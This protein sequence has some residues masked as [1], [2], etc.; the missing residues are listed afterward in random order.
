MRWWRQPV[1][2]HHVQGAVQHRRGARTLQ[3]ADFTAAK[4]GPTLGK[5]GRV[6]RRRG[7]N[8]RGFTWTLVDGSY[9]DVPHA[10]AVRPS[11]SPY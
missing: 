11:P 10:S 2:E 4:V 7:H 5:R 8:W 6:A 1:C 3:A 9:D